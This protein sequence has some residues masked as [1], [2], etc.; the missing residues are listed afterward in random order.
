MPQED[1]IESLLSFSL[2]PAHVALPASVELRVKM[3]ILDTLAASIAGRPAEGVAEVCA[4]IEE[5]GG[6]PQATILSNGYKSTAPLAALANG[7]AARAWD[8]DDV[9]EQN[10]CHVSANI[11]PATLA[12]SESEGS[13]SGTDLLAA[14]AVGMEVACRISGAPKLSFS[15]TGM[16]N[17][18]QSGYFGVALAAARMLHLDH[19]RARH[20]A[21]IAYS[22]IAGNQ[23]GYV[24]GAMTVR[25]MQGVTP[26]GGLIAA[27]MAQRGL[28]GSHKIL[29]GRFG[30]YETYHRYA[31]DRDVLIKQLGNEWHLE[32]ISIK[33]VYPCCKYTHGPIE[34]ALAAQRQAGISTR[35]IDRIDITVTN[36]E[37]YDLVC[38]P[39][40]RKW[41]PETIVDAQ[42]SLPYTVCYALTHA[43]MSLAAL[44]P[45]AIHDPYVRKLMERVHIHLE[46]ERQ[47]TGRGTFPMP[48]EIALTTHAGVRHEAI[49][50]HVKG[51]PQH[52]MSYEDV[53]EKLFQCA[54]Y[55]GLES[56]RARQLADTV[57]E[58]DRLSDVTPIISL[59]SA[60][61]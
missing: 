38:A 6:R 19:T 24:D 43:E 52:P 28:T 20:A 42:F 31:Y 59:A 51:H 4:L 36:K 47:G 9:H 21:G 32:D 50:T 34:A 46:T 2:D 41:N 40:E 58:I 44:Q 11:V 7:V 25:L 8:L 22:R 48:G 13:Y 3:A 33:P 16:A 5:W 39:R 53:A 37:V 12:L 1:A 54:E 15:E 17:S 27:L 35:D 57:Y 61:A 45:N 10:T 23:Q 14:I 26:E 29:E 18:Y 56:A 30:Y 55:A 49:V 60:H